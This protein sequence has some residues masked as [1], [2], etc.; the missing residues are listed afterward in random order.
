VVFAV[1]I[2]LL[3]LNLAVAGPGQRGTIT[4]GPRNLARY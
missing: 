3:A 1:A 2:T 4:T